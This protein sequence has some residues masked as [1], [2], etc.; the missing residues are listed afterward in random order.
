MSARQLGRIVPAQH[1]ADCQLGCKASARWQIVSS[2][3]NCKLSLNAQLQSLG[4]IVT[5]QLSWIC[6]FVHQICKQPHHQQLQGALISLS[7]ARSLQEAQH[8]DV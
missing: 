7:F 4:S 3:E 5:C 6:N 8:I 2:C 1:I